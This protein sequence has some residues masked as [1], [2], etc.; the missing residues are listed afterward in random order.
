MPLAVLAVGVISTGDM[1]KYPGSKLCISW[2]AGDLSQD[3]WLI[4][5]NSLIPKK[6]IFAMILGDDPRGKIIMKIFWIQ[7]DSFVIP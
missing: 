3:A 5:I 6:S 2:G 4:Q 7:G 1:D